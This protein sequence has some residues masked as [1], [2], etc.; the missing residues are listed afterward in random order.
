[1]CSKHRRARKE[2]QVKTVACLVATEHFMS[3]IHQQR[4]K[5]CIWSLTPTVP[6]IQLKMPDFPTLASITIQVICDG[7]SRGID[8]T[9]AA[10]KAT[11]MG[12]C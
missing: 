7:M 4:G 5:V 11:L 6:L 8:G 12:T 3:A 10:E 2:R 9:G 1:M